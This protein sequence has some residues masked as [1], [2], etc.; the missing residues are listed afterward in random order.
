MKMK[1]IPFYLFALFSAASWATEINACKDLI[2][3][4]K[5]TA[6]D[7]PYTM[8]I[9]P[10]VESCGEKCVKLNVQYELEVTHRKRFIAMK[11][12]RG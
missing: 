9:L 8:T 12:K 3:T 4:W 6:D 5:T 7:P 1:L 10:P 2:G 11:D